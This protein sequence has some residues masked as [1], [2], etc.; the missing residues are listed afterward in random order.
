MA[1][2]SDSGAAEDGRAILVPEVPQHAA[3]GLARRLEGSWLRVEDGLLVFVSAPGMLSS[4]HGRAKYPGFSLPIG[5][6]P[7]EAAELVLLRTPGALGGISWDDF[8][9]YAVLDSRRAVL[10][11]VPTGEAAPGGALELKRTACFPAEEVRRFAGRG[12]LGY[13]EESALPAP[14]MEHRYPGSSR[15]FGVRLAVYYVMTP[16]VIATGVYLVVLTLTGWDDWAPETRG[17]RV[18]S[19]VFGVVITALGFALAGLVV[20]IW[21]KTFKAR[22]QYERR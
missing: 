18:I 11:Y 22:R 10:G 7:S 9:C 13:R 4:R 21:A 3:R 14:E 5:N 6:A 15:G 12:G 8:S 20:A 16:A 17:F 1:A 2:V 19:L